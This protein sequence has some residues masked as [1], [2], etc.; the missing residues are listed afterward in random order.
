MVTYGRE[1]YHNY[2]HISLGFDVEFHTQKNGID[3]YVRI[4][5]NI[6]SFD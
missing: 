2:S 1:T 6:F 4:E 3:L 5:G